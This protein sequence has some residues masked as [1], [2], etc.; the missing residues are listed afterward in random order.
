M[1]EAIRKSIAE[2]SEFFDDITTSDLQGIVD[3]RASEI[4]KTKLYSKEAR[5]VAEQILTGI[6]A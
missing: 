2:F 5:E 1:Q 4:T 6:P 3:V